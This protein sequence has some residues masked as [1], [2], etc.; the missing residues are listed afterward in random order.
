MKILVTAGPTWAKVDPV[1]ILTSRF[2]GKTG[3]YLAESLAKKNHNL[4]LVLNPYVSGKVIGSFRTIYFYYFEQ[5]KEILEKE[6]KKARYD[7]VIHSAAVSDYLVKKPKKKKIASG[8]KGL[9]I[10][11]KPAPK[12][13][14]QIR[15]L[16]KDSLLIQFKLEVKEKGIINKAYQSL[17]S[18]GSDYVVA[19]ALESIKSSYKAR[20]ISREKEIVS[21]NSKK[22][23]AEII[24]RILESKS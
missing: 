7:A 3:I 24:N 22:E 10:S 18:N 9:D 12:I 8:G 2:T 4:T 21:I 16:A 15:R 6:L 13:I 17:K 1:R 14:R 5:F 20:L 11:L 23:L 19:N